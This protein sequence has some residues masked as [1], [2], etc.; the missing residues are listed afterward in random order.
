MARLLRKFYK[1]EVIKKKKKMSSGSSVVVFS[2]SSV[3]AARRRPPLG[4]ESRSCDQSELF[5]QDGSDPAVETKKV[6][7][8]KVSFLRI[9]EVVPDRIASLGTKVR[10]LRNRWV[11]LLGYGWQAFAVACG[12]PKV[13]RLRIQSGRLPVRPSRIAKVRF[14]RTVL[15]VTPCMFV[16]Y[17]K[18]S[19]AY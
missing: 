11:W 15:L 18:V 3:G 1:N 14:L 13:S 10:W 2:L 19:V 8:S 4:V 9:P 5:T 16:I 7:E 17:N 12:Y 6:L